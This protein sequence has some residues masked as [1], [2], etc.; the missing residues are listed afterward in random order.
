MTVLR[1]LLRLQVDE[2]DSPIGSGYRLS[3]AA[4]DDESHPAVCWV[5][6]VDDLYAAILARLDHHGR[7]VEPNEEQ[8]ADRGV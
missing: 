1:W 8:S 4:L 7:P 3:L 2:P 6:N 5:N